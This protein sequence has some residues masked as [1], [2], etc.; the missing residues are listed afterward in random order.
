MIQ[1]A[2]ELGSVIA[3]TLGAVVVLG[4]LA[5]VIHLLTEHGHILLSCVF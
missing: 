1:M 3:E 2:E 5:G 4:A